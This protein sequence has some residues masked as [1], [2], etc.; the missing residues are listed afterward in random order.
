MTIQECIEE[1]KLELTGGVLNLEIPDDTI[2]KVVEKSLRELQRYID[3]TR[4]VT[5]PF[6]KCIDLEGFNSSAIVS[7]FRTQGYT[8]DQNEG[9]NTSE[10]DPMY[11]QMWMSFANG[12]T[13]YNLNDYVLNYLSYNTLLQMRN[14]TSTDLSFREDKIGH[15]LY[16]NTAFD[17]PVKITIEYI[18]KFWNVEDIKD[19]YWID[20]LIRLSV[21]QTKL[22]LGRIRTRFKQSSALYTDDGDTILAEGTQEL[23]NIRTMLAEN[24]QLNYPID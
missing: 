8:G 11:A 16:I 23:E 7:V 14:T 3:E 13:M 6:S 20:L 19:D 17:T 21:A 5:V 9:I 1:I 4:F 12:S 15:K 2:R 22:I 24:A 10:V 18:P